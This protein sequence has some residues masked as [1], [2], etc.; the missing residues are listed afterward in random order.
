MK[1]IRDSNKNK[2]EASFPYIK[3]SL[4]IIGLSVNDTE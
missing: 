2:K 3:E 4:P 1:E